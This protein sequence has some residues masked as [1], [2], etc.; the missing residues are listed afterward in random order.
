MRQSRLRV[1]GWISKR[2]IP[3]THFFVNFLADHDPVFSVGLTTDKTG[4][5]T[6]DNPMAREM[7]SKERHESKRAAFKS[8]MTRV[9]EAV[10]GSLGLNNGF[11]EDKT[12]NER[13]L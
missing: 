7:F 4:V 8:P 9:A 12:Q 13:I 5:M 6:R 10:R 11:T 1:K 2:T 3:F